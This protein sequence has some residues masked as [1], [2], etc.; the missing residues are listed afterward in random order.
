MKILVLTE[1][2]LPEITAP[3][4]RT[5]DHARLWLADGHEVTVVTCVPNFPRGQVFPGYHKRFYQ[6][7]IIDGVRVVRIWSYM[8]ANE[9]LV[10]RTFDYI[11]YMLS[12]VAFARRYP[13]F[14]V[15]LA[16]SPPFFTAIAGW[17]VA[18]LRQRPWVFE[19]RDLWPASIR[20]VGASSSR[21]LD[22]L[23]KLELFL[24]RRADRI[25]S[26]TCSFKR[27]LVCRGIPADKNDV[28]TNAVDFDQFSR[29]RVTVNA[30][31]RLGV[32]NDAFLAGYVGTTGMAHG[33]ETMLDAAEKCLDDSRL[34]F[35]IMGEGAERVNLEAAAKR[36]GLSNV[37][38]HDFVSH[39]QVPS[40]LAALDVSIVHL[41]PDPVFKTV[42]P[43]KIFENMAMGVPMIMAVEGEAAE[44]V[45]EAGAG[46]CVPSGNGSIMA[47]TVRRLADNARLLDEMGRRGR[48]AVEA[49]YTRRANA[50]SCIHSFEAAIAS[51]RER[52]R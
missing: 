48:E 24:Y 52:R 17:L 37:I 19:I 16:T 42:I 47:D 18:S 32:P 29:S 14:D 7:E 25:I 35:L 46:L 4:F 15:L 40:Y 31:E 36:R 39:D 22:M 1:R 38:F 5:M 33:L 45:R 10:R 23:E 41:R 49:H 28:V 8:T 6:E 2:F 9:G 26:L 50:K 13:N 27:D 12:A 3:S 51:Y 11:S 44:I 21:A 34:R 20:A 43:S 30:R